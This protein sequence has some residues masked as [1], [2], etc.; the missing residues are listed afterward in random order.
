MYILWIEFPHQEAMEQMRRTS[1]A[2]G[3][4]EEEPRLLA[5]KF[6]KMT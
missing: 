2:I 4:V 5:W 1:D 6:L 3:V